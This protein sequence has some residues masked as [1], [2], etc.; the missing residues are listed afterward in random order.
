MKTNYATKL[1]TAKPM[2]KPAPPRKPVAPI[3]TAIVAGAIAI[4]GIFAALVLAYGTVNMNPADGKFPSGGKIMAHPSD[5]VKHL[6]EAL[7]RLN[8]YDGPI[9]GF[10]NHQTKQAITDLQ[11]EVGLQ[12]TGHMDLASWSALTTMLVEGNNQRNT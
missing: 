1:A 10:R 2:T 9:D 7:A 8:Y 11:R 12:Q 6:Q 5:E 4:G 3:V